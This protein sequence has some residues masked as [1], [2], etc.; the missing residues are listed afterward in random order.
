MTVYSMLTVAQSYILIRLLMTL[1]KMKRFGQFK[2]KNILMQFALF[3]LSFL[4]NLALYTQYLLTGG[5]HFSD[6]G[7]IDYQPF[8]DV[9]L[10]AII[11]MPID[12]IPIT[13][14]LFSHH[15]TLKSERKQRLLHLISNNCIHQTGNKPTQLY[16]PNNLLANQ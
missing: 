11:Y 16:Q 14:M 3:L 13:F 15:R 10:V 8:I 4:G 7:G 12:I 2:I 9:L 5:D 1:G 6:N